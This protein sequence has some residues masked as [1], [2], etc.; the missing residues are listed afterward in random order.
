MG[1]LPKPMKRPVTRRR[2]DSPATRSVLATDRLRSD[3][4]RLGAGN[5]DVASRQ[6]FGGGEGLGLPERHA[7]ASGR[8]RLPG[9]AGR[10]MLQE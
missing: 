4:S 10:M 9:N 6:G 7:S 2:D 3:G 1:A 8:D 5:T